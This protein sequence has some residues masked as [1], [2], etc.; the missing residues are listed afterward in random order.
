MTSS[1]QTHLFDLPTELIFKILQRLDTRSLVSVERVCVYLREQVTEY[2]QLFREYIFHQ[3]NREMIA[4]LDLCSETST[5]DHDYSDDMSDKI[6]DL[7]DELGDILDRLSW[8]SN[9]NDE[10]DD[11]PEQDFQAT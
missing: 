10:S 1:F 5:I 2:R 4:R 6:P 11:E 8:G 7:E 9:Y 3:E